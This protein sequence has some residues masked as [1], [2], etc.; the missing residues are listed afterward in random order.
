MSMSRFILTYRREGH[1]E[2]IE[3]VRFGN[4]SIAL[5]HFPDD[6]EWVG[7]R[8]FVSLENMEYLL[9]EF[10]TP[11]ITWLDGEDTVI[12]WSITVPAGTSV[13]VNRD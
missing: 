11:S 4:G 12:T 6:S 1:V 3:G 8:G 10:G 7:P 13:Q 2:E 9:N 5:E